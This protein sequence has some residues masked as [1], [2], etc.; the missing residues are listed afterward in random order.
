MRMRVSRLQ[1]GATLVEVLVAM[2]VFMIALLGLFAHITYS[3][4]AL[5]IESHRRT[6]AETAHSRLEL[7]RTVPYAS[8]ATYA[9]AD[10]AITLDA[11]DGAGVAATRTTEVVEVDEDGGGT[12]YRRVTV[13][14]NW[15][16]N[17]YEQEV[18]LSTIRT[19]YR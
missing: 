13:T 7:I 16:E 8:L 5:S 17:G 19:T 6:A 14:V 15:T 1:E 12:D 4:T 10:A 11:I 18:A 3:R 2:T 9:E